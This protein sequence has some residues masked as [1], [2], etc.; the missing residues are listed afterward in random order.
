MIYIIEEHN[1]AFYEIVK[2]VNDNEKYTLIHVDEH[3]DFGTPIILKNDLINYKVEK[4]LKDITYNQLRVSDYIIPLF[5]LGIIDTSIWLS[6]NEKEYYFEFVTFEEFVS[7]NHVMIGCKQVQPNG[8]NNK[9]LEVTLRSDIQPFIESKN[10]ILSIDLDYFS[11]SDEAGERTVIEI[12]EEEFIRFNSN[13]YH[14]CRLN[15]GSR[16]SCNTKDG[17]YYMVH[18]HMDGKFV[19]KQRSKDE[20]YNKLTEFEIFL[21]NNKVKPNIIIIC[22]SLISGYTPSHQYNDLLSNVLRIVNNICSLK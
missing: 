18:Q 4:N 10:I 9:F 20:I 15:F 12:T 17:K 16:I 22:K 8:N 5:H 6:N 19:N 7:C 1:E 21:K 11:C 14:K 13:L 2:L 3:H